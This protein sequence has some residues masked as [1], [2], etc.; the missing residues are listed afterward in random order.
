MLRL[1]STVASVLDLPLGRKLKIEDG[2]RASRRRKKAVVP[3]VIDTP[4]T[5]QSALHRIMI[6]VVEFTPQI[7]LTYPHLHQPHPFITS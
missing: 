4:G 3:R 6:T 5:R 2:S 1:A 7:S